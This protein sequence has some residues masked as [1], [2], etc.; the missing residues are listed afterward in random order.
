M[1]IFDGMKALLDDWKDNSSKTMGDWVF[2]KKELTLENKLCYYI[3]YL[4]EINSSAELLDWILQICSK[5]KNSFDF[6]NFVR[7][8][9]YAIRWNFHTSAQGAFSPSGRNIEGLNWR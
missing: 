1:D 5:D 6:E 7:L 3:V 2:D 4:D 8:L 9:T